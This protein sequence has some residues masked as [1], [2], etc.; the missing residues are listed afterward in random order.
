MKPTFDLWSQKDYITRMKKSALVRAR[1]EP[2]LKRKAEKILAE[3]GL[4]ASDAIHLLYRQV[5]LHQA[6]PFPLHTPNA[7]TAQAF[8]K[9]DV[10][11]DGVIDRLEVE[12]YIRKHQLVRGRENFAATRQETVE[13][14]VNA[15]MKELDTNNDGLISWMTFSEWHRR[16]S[17]ERMVKKHSVSPP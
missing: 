1:I 12:Y 5:A 3:L 10:E 11:G 6:L 8:K 16:N 17:I 9:L 4:N 15:L 14:T 2:A 7:A 13:A